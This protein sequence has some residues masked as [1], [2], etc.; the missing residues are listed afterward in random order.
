MVCGFLV[1]MGKDS[2]AMSSS[3]CIQPKKGTRR[4]GKKGTEA[5]KEAATQNDA[6]SAE[7]PHV[8]VIFTAK[9]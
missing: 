9:S 3:R 2:T 5:I 6:L 7:Q 4:Q 8:M 1:K